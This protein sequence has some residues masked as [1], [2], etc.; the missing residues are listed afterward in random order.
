[1]SSVNNPEDGEFVDHLPLMEEKLGGEAFIGELC[2]GFDLLKDED[3]GLITFDSLKK[4]AAYM[5]LQNLSDKELRDM[6]KEGDYDGD[7]AISQ[8]EF[9]VLMFRSCPRL[10]EQAE[11][12][13]QQE[14]QFLY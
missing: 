4:N 6:I 13:L 14:L 12:L 11:D 5:G 1:M 10:M 9:C 3:K 2:K 8:M 7:G